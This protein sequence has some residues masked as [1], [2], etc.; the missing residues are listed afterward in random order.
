MD[1]EDEDVNVDE[2]IDSVYD[3]NIA[4]VKGECVKGKNRQTVTD[5][6]AFTE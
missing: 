6:N 2:V 4:I 3:S 1:T 5:S